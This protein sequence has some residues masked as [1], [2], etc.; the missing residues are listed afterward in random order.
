ML[1]FLRHKSDTLLTH[2][3][4]LVDIAP[5]KNMYFILL[6]IIQALFGHIS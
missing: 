6:M 2:K 4:Y 3:N 1:Y 5:F